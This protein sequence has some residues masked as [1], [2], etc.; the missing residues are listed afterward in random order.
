MSNGKRKSPMHGVL[1]D[2]DNY[3][4]GANHILTRLWRMTLKSQRIDENR[5]EQLL[6]AWRAKE[7]KLSSRAE[8]TTRRNNVVGALASDR[9]T[10]KTFY[11]GLEILNAMRRYKLIRFE[12]HLVPRRGGEADVIALDVLGDSK[13]DR[14]SHQIAE[15][16]GRD[17]IHTLLPNEMAIAGTHYQLSGF[18]NATFNGLVVRYIGLES[19][20][21]TALEFDGCT[22]V[23]AMVVGPTGDVI[24]DWRVAEME[25]K[26]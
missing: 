23:G 10:W 25:G 15:A 18:H 19:R 2:L 21:V 13:K 20:T 12:I 7:E 16:I 24:K 8:A 3:I 11:T 4:S 17:K 26:A 9:M 1:K 5:W 14:R 22:A 6:E